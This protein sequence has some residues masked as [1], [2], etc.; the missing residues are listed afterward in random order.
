MRQLDNPFVW[1]A[2][3][4]LVYWLALCALAVLTRGGL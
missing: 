3:C 2:A 4:V 1:L